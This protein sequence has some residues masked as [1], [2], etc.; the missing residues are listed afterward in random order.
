MQERAS[1]LPALAALQGAGLAFA[2][3][4]APSPESSVARAS[5]FTGLDVAA[6]GVWTDGVALSKRDMPLPQGFARAGY[7]SWLV[8]R[9]QLAGVSGW[10]TE[11]ARL[12]EYHH[13]DWAHGPLHRSR[14]N[15]YLTWLQVA[16]PETYAKIFPRQ[17]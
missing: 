16:E 3:A 7:V 6:H 12:D 15:A 11:H 9:R 2:N 14:Q 5:L 13:F 8:G 17:A 1:E 10:T 4:Y